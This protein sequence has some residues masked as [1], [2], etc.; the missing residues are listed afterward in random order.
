M[1][2]WRVL[3]PLTG[4]SRSFARD[5]RGVSVAITH[6]LTIA[7]TG[8]LLIGLLSASGTLLD[9]QEER[10]SHDQLSEINGDVMSHIN[11]VDRL[12]ATGQNVS[13]TL[14]LDYPDRIIDSHNYR[15][16]LR[17]DGSGQGV[18]E[19]SVSRLDQS[20][21]RKIDTD[22]DIVPGRVTGSNVTVSLCDESITLGG[23]P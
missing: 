4:R 22:A 3:V 16:E 1:R 13:M 20:V 12:A 15:I 10:I 23:C 7:I 6:G 21:T 2:D 8:V 9:T 14:T 17:T 19:V 11:T 5:T 18:L